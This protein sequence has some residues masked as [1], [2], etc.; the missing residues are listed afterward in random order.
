MTDTSRDDY[1]LTSAEPEASHPSSRA[2]SV[3]QAGSLSDAAAGSTAQALPEGQ[4]DSNSQKKKLRKDLKSKFLFQRRISI[5][6]Q[7]DQQFANCHR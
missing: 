4:N 2:S 5:Q 7:A 6:A 3:T 1:A